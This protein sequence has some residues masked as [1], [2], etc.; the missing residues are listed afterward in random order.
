MSRH[1]LDISAVNKKKNKPAAPR[2]SEILSLLSREITFGNG[3]LV[4]KKKESFYHELGTLIRSGI[5]IK[6]ALEL[7]TS[8]FSKHADRIMFDA[9]KQEV[10]KGKS[11][12]ESLQ[13]QGKFSSYEFFSV[14]IGE[15]TGKLGEVL[16]ELG[17]Y[18]K[19]KISQRRKVI[20]AITYP[21]LVLSTSFSAIFFMIKFVVPMFADVF[22]RFGGKLPYVTSLIISF[23]DWFDRYIYVLLFLLLG[24]VAG[25][26]LSRK[27]AWF[28][29]N[30]AEFV[31]KIPMIGDLVQKIYLAR[32]ANTMRLLTETNTPLLSA[33]GMVR[34]MIGFYPI[35]HSLHE[36]EKDILLGKSLSESLGKDA[37]YPEKFIQMI[38][39]AEEVNK[40]SYFF[41]QLSEQYTEEVEYKTTAIS[42]MLE[43]LIIIFLGITVGVILI[44]MYLPMFQM[45][46][47]F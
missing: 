34:E 46:N 6:S 12:S 19:S 3:Q 27:T 25:Y 17:R 43:P 41:G 39:I 24:L 33:M 32:F 8:S 9:I 4:D 30:S 29:R 16:G 7:S 18:Y 28:S 15:E 35:E 13:G 47:T 10:V 22:K 21:V 31:L 14:R 23:S 37:F 20:S 1:S 45:S 40:L 44:A 11:L 38:R 5:D 2:Q 36:A 42:G 26:L